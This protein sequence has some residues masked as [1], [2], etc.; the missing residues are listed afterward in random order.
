MTTS[1]DGRNSMGK[2]HQSW[3]LLTWV[4]YLLILWGDPAVHHGLS[5]P[6]ALL[7][8]FFR[9]H[10]LFLTSSSLLGNDPKRNAWTRK[11]WIFFLNFYTELFVL[12][13]YP[14]STGKTMRRILGTGHFLFCWLSI[15][16]DFVDLAKVNQQDKMS[17]MCWSTE[18][19]PSRWSVL[20]DLSLC[21]HLHISVHLMLCQIKYF[22]KGSD[23]HQISC[24][25]GW[26]LLHMVQLLNLTVINFPTVP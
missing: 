20:A 17:V 14:V 26:L 5:F 9:A 24:Y 16:D 8:G 7:D 15:S 1:N 18:L 3:T 22:R 11:M 12:F 4:Q 23:Q 25:S 2:T 6:S 10:F 19:S 13:H 21:L